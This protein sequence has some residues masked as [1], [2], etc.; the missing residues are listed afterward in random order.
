MNGRMLLLLRCFLAITFCFLRI[1]ANAQA[2]TD[3]IPDTLSFSPTLSATADSLLP[4]NDTIP[5]DSSQKSQTN[6]KRISKGAVEKTVTY[7][8]KDSIVVDIKNRM[9]YLFGDAVVYYDDL[10]LH[11]DFIQLGFASQELYFNKSSSCLSQS[12]LY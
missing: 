11:A 2:V 8:A 5:Q 3:T 12:V 10:E 1:C 7:D 9:A 6:G 4:E